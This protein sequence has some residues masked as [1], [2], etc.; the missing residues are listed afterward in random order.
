M[1]NPILSNFTDDGAWLAEKAYSL[2]PRSIP[3][4]FTTADKKKNKIRAGVTAGAYMGGSMVVRGLQGGGIT[5]NEYG[6][7]DIVGIP[8]I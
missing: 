2:N 7:R 1:N 8:F 3:A 4:Y 5:T 6:E